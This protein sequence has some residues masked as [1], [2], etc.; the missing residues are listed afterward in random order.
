LYEVA[1]WIKFEKKSYGIRV[2]IPAYG[3]LFKFIIKTP[4]IAPL[5]T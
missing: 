1:H 5:E 4:F 2:R 3:L